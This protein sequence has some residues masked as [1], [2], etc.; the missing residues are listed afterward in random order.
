MQNSI[1]RSAYRFWEILPG[2]CSWTILLMPFVF[3]FVWPAGVAYFI[4]VFDSY[5]VIKSLVMGGY[6][7]S[8]WAHLK[9][10][11]KIDWMKR[12]KATENL[13]LWAED[14]TR[15]IKSSFGWQASKFR[16]EL[17]A[18]NKLRSM[19]EVQKDWRSI[20]HAELLAVYKESETV[21][22]NSI[23]SA[24]ATGYPA[25][26]I[27][28]VL[29]AEERAGEAQVGLI[30]KLAEE[31]KS[32]FADALVFV[33]PDG[34]P[35]EIKAKGANVSW[36]LR[37]FR[38]YL[39]EK[40]IAYDDVVVSIF[41]AD[42]VVH[43]KYFAC[44]TYNYITNTERT[45]RSYQPLPVFN[46][47]IWD[48]PAWNRLVALSSSF[49]QVIES[50]RPYRL[51]T[52][53]SQAASM[54]TLVEVDYVDPMVVSEDSRQFFRSYYHYLGDYKVVPIFMPVSMD[55]VL[56]EKGYWATLKAQYIQKRRWA[57][58]IEHFPYLVEKFFV[59]RKQMSFYD[60]FINVW[61][62]FEGH[63]SWSTSSMVI[64]LGGWLPLLNHSFRNTVLA[65]NLPILASDMLRIT[66][67]GIFIMAGVAF[68]LLPARP[69]D[70]NGFWVQLVGLAEWIL[71]PISGVVFGSIP[72]ID[73][74]TRLMLGQYLGFKVTEK[75]RAKTEISG[76]TDTFKTT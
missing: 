34:L 4:I 43:P 39:D 58:G 32:R 49:W 37:H 27:I 22:R 6:L 76:S 51:V 20:Y 68:T 57:Y 64:L 35:N 55:A 13:D 71:T 72:A 53:S 10:G 30:R 52:F 19:P 2:V 46:N 75:H 67:V 15:Q 21:L 5:W 48:V 69:K 42:T 12:L 28:L 24:L 47:N 17:V 9:R 16:D 14:L 18:I 3:S 33:H 11:L 65:F 25:Q 29:A 62:S 66:W 61:R 31:Y 38:P 45:R 44:L 70:R 23:E 54:Q 50:T 73:A 7:V 1:S 74:E 56:S 63:I 36:A 40:Q 60:R 26:N 8:G 41:D 59:M